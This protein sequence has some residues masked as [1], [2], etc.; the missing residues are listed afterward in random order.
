L[1][2]DSTDAR[3][4]REELLRRLAG[5]GYIRLTGFH[6]REAV[7][8]ARAGVLAAP[9]AKAAMQTE[10]LVELVAGPRVLSFFSWLVG[11]EAM[12]YDYRWV[13]V[14]MRGQR[15]SVHCDRVFMGRGTERVL[16]CWNPLGDIPVGLGPLALWLGSGHQ[17]Q[18][19]RTYGAHDV[20]RD[21]IDGYVAHDP[22]ECV[23]SMGGQWHSA[24]FEAGD[25]VIFGMH[26]LHGSLDN[27]TDEVRVS[28]DTR[29]Q[30]AHEAV[31]DRWVGSPPAGHDRWP[32]ATL[33][34]L[35]AG[36]LR[37]GLPPIAVATPPSP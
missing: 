27:T 8:A 2:A 12:T 18:I 28:C 21:L 17:E 6:P 13:R 26:T 4:D 7:L 20:D 35:A 36:R 16:T 24:N 29:Y 3:D 32:Y 19:E 15:T 9:H 11:A 34:S 30:P 14:V 1:L 22:W 33:E 31:D 5:D 25:V 37:W 10:G 23:A